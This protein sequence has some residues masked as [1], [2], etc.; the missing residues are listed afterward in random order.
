MP[1]AAPSRRQPGPPGHAPAAALLAAALL[2]AWPAT[3]GAEGAPAVEAPAAAAPA[4][5]P[6]PA[7]PPPAWVR[8]RDTRVFEL[9]VAHGDVGPEERARAASEAL[10]RALGAERTGRASVEP[11][12]RGAVI[13]LAGVTI[14]ELWPEDAAAAGEARLE[15]LAVEV[16]ARLDEAVAAERRRRT[17]QDWVFSF[18]LAVFSGLVAVVLLRRLVRLEADLEQWADA[19][20]GRLPALSVGGVEVASPA[21]VRGGLRVALRGAR[22]LAQVAVA[23]VWLLFALSVFPQTASTGARLRDTALAPVTELVGR[24]GRALPLLAVFAVAAAVLWLVLRSVR[25]FLGS[26]ARGETHLGWLPADLAP[27]VSAVLRGAIVVGALAFAAPLIGGSESGALAIAGAVALAAVGL[28]VVPLLA[29]VALGLPAVFGRAYR[30]G[31]RAEL[32]GRRG[33]VREVGL[34]GI[35]LKD[36]E[37]GELRVSHLAAALHP[38]WVAPAEPLGAVEVVVAA[39]ED[40]ERVRDLL[41]V[42][43]GVPTGSAEL[44]SLD[45]DGARWVVR[46]ARAGLGARVAAALT[47]GGIRLGPAPRAAP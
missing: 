39:G 29:T 9:R 8:L 5:A 15:S 44:L 17:L 34:L 11:K 3:V 31:E 18:S 2:S 46:G 23:W 47:K 26:V 43:A 33:L 13:R 37:G 19:R 42:A 16:T 32:A 1:D 25:L 45:R 35:R 28:S 22:V 21:A 10:A 6:A 7:A 20:P 30:P 12:G 38:A 40:P 41:L 27:S 24:L 4:P 36:D 14:V